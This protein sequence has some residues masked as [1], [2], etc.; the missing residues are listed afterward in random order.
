[1]LILPYKFCRISHLLFVIAI[2]VEC[3]DGD[4]KFKNGTTANRGQVEFCHEG[5]WMSVCNNGWGIN[6]ARSV[7]NQLKFD[8]EGV[9]VFTTQP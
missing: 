3:N 4:V 1:M 8:P 2:A 6:E 9:F 5:R 7:C